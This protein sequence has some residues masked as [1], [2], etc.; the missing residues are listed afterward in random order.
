[1]KQKDV[2]SRFRPLPGTNAN[3]A[4]FIGL[5]WSSGNDSAKAKARN[6]FKERLKQDFWRKDLTWKHTQEW[7]VGKD[8]KMLSKLP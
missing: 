5:S 1:M 3:F 8:L 6:V 7:L 2:E 4:E